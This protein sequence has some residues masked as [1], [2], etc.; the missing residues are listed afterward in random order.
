VLLKEKAEWLQVL[1]ALKEGKKNDPEFR[2]LLNRISTDP[3]HSFQ[4]SAA[5]LQQTLAG[6]WV[7]WVD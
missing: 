6:F 7:R 1:I 2:Q 3:N 5:A 4:P